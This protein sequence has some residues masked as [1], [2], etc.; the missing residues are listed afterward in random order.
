MPSSYNQ[1]RT[2]MLNYQVLSNIYENRKHHKLKEWHDMCDWIE[3]LPYAD[4]LIYQSKREQVK[5]TVE[6]AEK[7]EKTLEKP[8]IISQN[9]V[10]IK[11]T[12]DLK[13]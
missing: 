6:K 8:I 11:P 2:C 12:T 4:G 9:N 13:F 1:T 5:E 3:A 7:A 10:K